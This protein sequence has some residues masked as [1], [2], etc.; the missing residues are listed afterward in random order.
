M[1]GSSG[2]LLGTAVGVALQN[3]EAIRRA[4]APAMNTVGGVAT[5]IFR[6][7]WKSAALG[8]GFLVVWFA[9]FATSYILGGTNVLA[10]P[11]AMFLFGIFLFVV[12][13]TVVFLLE[14]KK[15]RKSVAAK[16]QAQREAY[17]AHMAQVAAQQEREEQERREAAE[18]AA[19]QQAQQEKAFAEYRQ[20]QQAYTPQTEVLPQQPMPTR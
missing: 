8:A 18:F 19:Y 11:T 12:L 10:R 6:T 16:N 15:V 9:A 5:L 17:Q 4:T 13:P 20:A 7:A 3:Q 1:S 2:K 14:S